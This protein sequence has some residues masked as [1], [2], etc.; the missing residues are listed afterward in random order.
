MYIQGRW[1]LKNIHPQLVPCRNLYLSQLVQYPIPITF[2]SFNALIVT[3]TSFVE[4]RNG[5]HL[6]FP[7]ASN[8]DNNRSVSIVFKFP[9]A[10]TVAKIGRIPFIALSRDMNRNNGK[11]MFQDIFFNVSFQSFRIGIKRYVVCLQYSC[12]KS[13]IS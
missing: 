11:T 8:P 6:S 13:S 12:D 7:F 10:Q 4:E 9:R 5:L 2:A 1:G 3:E